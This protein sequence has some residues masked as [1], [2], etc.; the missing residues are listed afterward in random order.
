M[1]RHTIPETFQIPLQA[2]LVQSFFVQLFT[3]FFIRFFTLCTRYNFNAFVQQVG[4]YR[5]RLAMF[6]NGL[7]MIKRTGLPWP[8]CDI[9]EIRTVMFFDVFTPCLFFGSS[10]VRLFRRTP[11]FTQNFFGTCHRNAWD[12]FL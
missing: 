1:W 11:H 10:Y 12:W 2:F 7:F 6:A 9:H 4:R 8:F 5:Y 3:Q